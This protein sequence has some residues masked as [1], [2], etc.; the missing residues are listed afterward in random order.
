MKR[1]VTLGA[2][3]AVIA[4]GALGAT[5]SA[6]SGTSN[7]PVIT[8]ALSKGPIAVSG[9]LQSG[10][11]N[12]HLTTG[13]PQAS[14]ALLRLNPGVTA[15]QVEAFAGTKAA[16]D[17]NNVARFGRTVFDAEA[18]KGTTDVQTTLEP[19]D[20]VAVDTTA[21]NPSKFTFASFT[22]AQASQPAVLPAPKATVSSIEFGFKAPKTLRNGDLVRFKNAGF[23]SHMIVGIRVDNATAARKLE[24]AMRAGNQKKQRSLARGF[25]PFLFPV[26]PGVFEQ[27]KVKAQPGLYVLA[28]FEDTQDH[29]E[30]TKLRMYR[31]IRIV[32]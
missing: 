23:L 31:V 4:A 14:A 13:E 7:L 30:H 24:A 19:G 18:P 9:A 15:A 25:A 6:Q 8:I 16:M 26:S 17:S 10:G 21:D 11:V 12:V 3:A 27:F 29:R 1:I 22:I 20:Y 5:S 2:A 28:C 32:G